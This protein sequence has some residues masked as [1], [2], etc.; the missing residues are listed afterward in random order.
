MKGAPD[1]LG[2]VKRYAKCMPCLK[3]RKE[4][5]GGAPLLPRSSKRRTSSGLRSVRLELVRDPP[6]GEPMTLPT[7]REWKEGLRWQRQ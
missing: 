4:K 1:D 2:E 6:T 5:I 7:E 3:E